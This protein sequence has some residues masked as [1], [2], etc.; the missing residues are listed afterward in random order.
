MRLNWDV[1]PHLVMSPVKENS[2]VNSWVFFKSKSL[3]LSALIWIHS[4]ELGFPLRDH[5]WVP[6]GFRAITLPPCPWKA[7]GEVEATRRVYLLVQL[8]WGMKF[9]AAK[10]VPTKTFRIFPTR[11]PGWI[12]KFAI[13]W[14]LYLGH[15]LW[16]I[17][18]H[19]RSP[20][21]ETIPN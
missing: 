19:T 9:C 14:S 20:T 18:S 8:L 1:F 17:Q 7:P 16:A 6:G 3:W 4:S 12:R 10:C 11:S 15:I 21:K 13:D 5:P 2:G